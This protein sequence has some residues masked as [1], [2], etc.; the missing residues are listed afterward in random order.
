MSSLLI[1][2]EKTESLLTNIRTDK[3]KHRNS[4]AVQ[5]LLKFRV[6]ISLGAIKCK[7]LNDKQ[8]DRHIQF[9]I[10]TVSLLKKLIH[11]V[12]N[13]V[14]KKSPIEVEREKKLAL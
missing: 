5:K 8:T 9:Y 3:V 11:S 12:F 6:N 10:E 2:P 1:C 7:K 14:W 13:V 4:C